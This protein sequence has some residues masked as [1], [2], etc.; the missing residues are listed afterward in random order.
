MIAALATLD[1]NCPI[2]LWDRF[3]PQVQDTLNL[4][5]TSRDNAAIS[6]YEALEGPMNF[7]KTPISILGMRALAYLNPDDRASWQPHGV[8]VFYTARC[9][10][11]YRMLEFFDPITRSYRTQALQT[12]SYAL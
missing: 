3:L 8:N 10:L 4:L 5:R 9:P 6:A 12:L 2:Q 1:I 7:N 11:H